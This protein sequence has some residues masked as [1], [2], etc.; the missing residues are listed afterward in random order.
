MSINHYEETT[1]VLLFLLKLFSSHHILFRT[2]WRTDVLFSVAVVR[3]GVLEDVLGLEDTFWSPWPWPR[4]SSPWPWPRGLKSSKIGLSSVRGQHYFLNCQNVVE[5]LKNF[6]E[7]VFLWRSL[8]KFLWRPFFWR[9]LALVYLVL[10]LGLEHS[11]PWP[12]ECLSSESL[13]L[14]LASDFFCVLGFGLEPYVLDSTSGSSSTFIFFV[15]NTHVY[16]FNNTLWI[17]KEKKK[18]NSDILVR[19][20]ERPHVKS[21]G[22]TCAV[23]ESAASHLNVDAANGYKSTQTKNK[24][25]K[26]KSKEQNESKI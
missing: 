5:R 22:W 8:E 19:G 2:S 26:G 14:V 25:K 21:N 24:I 1:L 18:R 10:G 6:L 13:S 3:G 17:T 23:V 11:C 4:R 7:N 15:R 12:R 20:C 16:N 9:A